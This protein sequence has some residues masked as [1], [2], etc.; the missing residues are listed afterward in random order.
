MVPKAGESLVIRWA[1]SHLLV[2]EGILVTIVSLE[3]ITHPLEAI[4]LV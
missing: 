3:G 4:D 1:L 2:S